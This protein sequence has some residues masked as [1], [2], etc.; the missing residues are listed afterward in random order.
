MQ[1]ERVLLL[2]DSI[3]Q[4]IPNWNQGRGNTRY[5]VETICFRGCTI[6]RLASKIE[7]NRVNI[8]PYHKLI[9]HIGTN[10]IMT[11]TW[12][13]TRLDFIELLGQIQTNNPNARIIFSLPV[14]RPRD[15]GR[16]WPK[17]D[18]L[19]KWLI[20]HQR[21]GNYKIW[22]TYKT[23]LQKR[24]WLWELPEIKSTLDYKHDG[25]HLSSSG[26]LIMLQQLKMAI[27]L[28]R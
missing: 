27:S 18:A 19:N 8:A 16:S 1:T 14:P 9:I 6:S 24:T 22:R 4:N 13:D 2:G 15:M 10:D 20:K 23:F 12:S 7:R 28:I 17:Q 21:R 5:Q 3:I 25:L 11:S 26:S